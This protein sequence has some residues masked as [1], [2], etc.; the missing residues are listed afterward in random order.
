M[1][2][3]VRGIGWFRNLFRDHAA[4]ISSIRIVDVLY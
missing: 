1:K 4:R 2:D 3:R